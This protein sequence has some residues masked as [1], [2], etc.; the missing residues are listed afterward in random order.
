MTHKVPEDGLCLENSVYFTIG[1]NDGIF[2]KYTKVGL[3]GSNQLRMQHLRTLPGR[4]SAFDLIERL[5]GTLRHVTRWSR[6][7]P[8]LQIKVICNLQLNQSVGF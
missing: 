6:H 7:E 2:L 5:R 4:Q 1:R 3:D 8:T